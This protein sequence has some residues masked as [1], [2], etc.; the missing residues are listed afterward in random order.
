MALL[1]S[2]G[3][4]TDAQLTD[5]FQPYATDETQSV[6]L[7]TGVRTPGFAILSNSALTLGHMEIGYFQGTCMTGW[8][9]SHS[10]MVYS[11]GN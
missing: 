4:K 3:P 7:S 2:Q 10:L 8:A 9:L 1:R 6:G 5:A 11:P